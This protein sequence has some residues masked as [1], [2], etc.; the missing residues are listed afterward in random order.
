MYSEPSDVND[1]LHTSNIILNAVQEGDSFI[2]MFKSWLLGAY[3]SEDSVSHPFE[4]LI[5]NLFTIIV[6]VDMFLFSWIITGVEEILE[7]LG[8]SLFPEEFHFFVLVN[9]RFSG[10]FNLMEVV[11]N[12]LHGSI[13]LELIFDFNKIITCCCINT[14]WNLYSNR[15]E[16]INDLLEDISDTTLFCVGLDCGVEDNCSFTVIEVF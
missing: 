5:F 6:E 12:N 9:E 8:K 4:G 1:G 13:Q 3:S 7:R 10:N 14:A 16:V 15:N 11:L 2:K